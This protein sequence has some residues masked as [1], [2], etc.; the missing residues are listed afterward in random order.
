MDKS[1]N[2]KTYG[3]EETT[4]GKPGFLVL[5]SFSWFQMP[6][7]HSDFV[8]LRQNRVLPRHNYKLYGH[9]I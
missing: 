5:L 8:Y 9:A 4:F 7:S 2:L 1:E 3:S 6:F